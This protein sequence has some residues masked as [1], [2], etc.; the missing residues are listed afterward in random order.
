VELALTAPTVLA[1]NFRENL[2]NFF[3]DF[4]AE[5]FAGRKR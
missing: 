1:L 3:A 2:P 4:A 5:G